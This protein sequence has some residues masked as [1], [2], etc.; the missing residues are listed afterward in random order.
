MSRYST[1]DRLLL[2]EARAEAARLGVKLPTRIC[3]LKVGR[4]QYAV[5]ADFPHNFD[6]YVKASSASEAKAEWISQLIEAARPER[7]LEQLREEVESQRCPVC[8]MG[9]NQ[10]F[11]E[12]PKAGTR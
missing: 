7:E 10:H 6:H 8:N 4:Q 12:C 11:A 5:Q 2:K 1:F 9:G 3:A